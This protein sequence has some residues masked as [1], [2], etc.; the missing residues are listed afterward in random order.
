MGIW[1]TA[2]NTNSLDRK[3][4]NNFDEVHRLCE[5]HY[6]FDV[7]EAIDPLFKKLLHYHY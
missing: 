7:F 1:K 4:Y 2:A 6:T 5:G 3:Y